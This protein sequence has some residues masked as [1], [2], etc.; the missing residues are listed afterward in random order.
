MLLKRGEF[1]RNHLFCNKCIGWAKNEVLRLRERPPPPPQSN[2][3][4][5]PISDAEASRSTPDPFNEALVNDVMFPDGSSIIANRL[6]NPTDLPIH[7]GNRKS[8]VE[9]T[10]QSLKHDISFAFSQQCHL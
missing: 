7:L 2:P 6:A 9:H 10:S 4:Y 5:S 8:I 1:K 3:Q